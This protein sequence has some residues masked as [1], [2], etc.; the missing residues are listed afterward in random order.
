MGILRCFAPS[1]G[2]NVPLK[3]L[4]KV[5]PFSLI[6]NLTI[7]LTEDNT[8]LT[9]EDDNPRVTDNLQTVLRQIFSS[10][11]NFRALSILPDNKNFC[12][13]LHK[14]ICFCRCLLGR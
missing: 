14:K 9:D 11:I 5:S 10:L 8:C 13:I 1:L 7:D 2:V 4:V 6:A 12:L 3:T